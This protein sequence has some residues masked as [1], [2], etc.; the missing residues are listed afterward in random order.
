[1]SFPTRR[2]SDLLV[3]ARIDVFDPE[4][5]KIHRVS[6]WS[7][8]NGRFEIEEIPRFPRHEE[9]GTLPIRM[10]ISA[11]EYPIV[12]WTEYATRDELD[13]GFKDV[14]IEIRRFV[15]T[16]TLLLEGD[17]LVKA[18]VR[19]DHE[20][21][22]GGVLTDESGLFELPFAFGSRGTHTLIVRSDR[23]DV[24]TVRIENVPLHPPYPTR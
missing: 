8:A 13:A 15:V 9:S 23:R 16:G 10:G 20:R 14:E 7:D 17:P 21:D 19:V 24:W 18:D 6:A 5:E 2:S 3:D 12:R 4:K 22:P 11:P 1:S